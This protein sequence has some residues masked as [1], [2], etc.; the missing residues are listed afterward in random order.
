MEMNMT[1]KHFE[2]LAVHIRVILDENARFAAAIA[3][4][5]ALRDTNPRFDTNRFLQACGV[6]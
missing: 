1:K 6:I 2:S 5:T 4:A 3:V